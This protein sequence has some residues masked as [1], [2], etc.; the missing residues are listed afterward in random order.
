MCPC[1]SCLYERQKQIVLFFQELEEQLDQK[2]RTIKKLLNHIKSL[3]T[4]QKGDAAV[5]T[6]TL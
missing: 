6:H 5:C 3:E 1:M 4:S 2:D